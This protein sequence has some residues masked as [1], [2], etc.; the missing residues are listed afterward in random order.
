[1]HEIELALKV[2]ETAILVKEGKILACGPPEEVLGGKAVAQLYDINCAYFSD[3]LGSVEL[4]NNGKTQIYVLAGA[5][6]GARVY[7][8]LNKHGFG[9]I[10]GVINENDVDY[11]VAKAIG[12]TV[13][14]EKPFEQIG[15]ASFARAVEFMQRASCFVDAGFPVGS[16]NRRNIVLARLAL[17]RGEALYTMRN[18]QEA[19]ALYGVVSGQL[20]HCHSLTELVGNVNGGNG[21]G[22]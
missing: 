3:C 9:V 21:Y 6:S 11:H 12:A 13:I 15:A 19:R 7:R 18:K 4:K 16:L 1:M 17:A 20:I 14:D 8:L 2:C 5:G 10:T 22:A